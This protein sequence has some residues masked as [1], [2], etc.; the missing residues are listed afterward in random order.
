MTISTNRV[1]RWEQNRRYTISL[2]TG[3]SRWSRGYYISAEAIVRDELCELMDVFRSRLQLSL[4][5]RFSTNQSQ[6]SRFFVLYLPSASNNIL[7]SL[8]FF[9]PTILILKSKKFCYASQ[10]A[11]FKNS[12]ACAQS[13]RCSVCIGWNV[14]GWDEVD[15]IPKSGS[16][17]SVIIWLRVES[18]VKQRQPR[19]R[20]KKKCVG[21]FQQKHKLF[22]SAGE[23]VSSVWKMSK[24][25][26]ANFR[27]PKDFTLNSSCCDRR[28]QGLEMSVY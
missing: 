12:E 18:A 6:T 16:C 4:K 7:D 17:S 19:K 1:L 24:C 9:F 3:L 5:T 11:T 20:K 15:G 23:I 22:L 26:I 13:V 10:I 27:L 25:H 8:N 2:A 14:C 28:P 21:I